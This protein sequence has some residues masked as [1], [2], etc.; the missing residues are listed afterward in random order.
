MKTVYLHIGNFKTGTSAI[1]ASCSRNRDLLLENGI[2]YLLSGRTPLKKSF[3]L[4]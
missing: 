3:R 2:D 1:Q 4:P